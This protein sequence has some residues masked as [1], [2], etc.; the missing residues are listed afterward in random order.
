MFK[1]VIRKQVLI[2][3][4]R[5]H[6]VSGWTTGKGLTNL[7]NNC[8][9]VTEM[10]PIFYDSQK[11]K[12]VSESSSFIIARWSY[13]QVAGVKAWDFRHKKAQLVTTSFTKI[14]QGWESCT[15][16]VFLPPCSA[17]VPLPPK[18]ST[19][20][21]GVLPLSLSFSYFLF[22]QLSLFFIVPSLPRALRGLA[23][24]KYFRCNFSPP[25]NKCC[26]RRQAGERLKPD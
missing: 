25:V 10:S 1:W 21:I 2:Y 16:R 5:T 15:H 23:F 18:L 8:L 9:E 6:R 14:S 26:D 13:L 20:R 7:K 24:G 11:R 4:T 3:R 17:L 12:W 22:T 19:S